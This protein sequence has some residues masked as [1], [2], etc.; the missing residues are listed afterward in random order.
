MSGKDL[1]ASPS[2][3]RADRSDWAPH[4]LTTLGAFVVVGMLAAGALVLFDARQDAWRL[5][6]QS[7]SNLIGSI[8]RDITHVINVYDRS[9]Q[10]LVRRIE[11]PNGANVMSSALDAELVD[12]TTLA[13]YAG[14]M[15]VANPQGGVIASSQ[16]QGLTLDISD[17]DYFQA[18]RDRVDAGLFLS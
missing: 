1:A 9:F 15:I 5:A 2:E 4:R 11:A 18:Q 17:R 12:R 6:E 13:E 16:S 7:S 3:F 8:E 10:G 14:W